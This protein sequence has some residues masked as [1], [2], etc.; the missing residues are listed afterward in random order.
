MLEGSL[1]QREGGRTVP[2]V[3]YAGNSP[4]E[5]VGALLDP[6]WRRGEAFNVMRPVDCPGVVCLLAFGG[7]LLGHCQIGYRGGALAGGDL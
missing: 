1:A 6:R 2:E 5:Q 7:P 3:L 4:G